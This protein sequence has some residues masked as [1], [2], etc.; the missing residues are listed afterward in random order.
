MFELKRTW[1]RGGRGG[2]RKSTTLYF[3]N[4]REKLVYT[5]VIMQ[6]VISFDG[7]DLQTKQA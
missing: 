2:E 3:T 7:G 4:I 5:E 6:A 1:R